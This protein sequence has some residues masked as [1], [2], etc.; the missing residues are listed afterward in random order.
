MGLEVFKTG[1]AAEVIPCVLVFQCS[2]CILLF[3]IH[4]AHRIV[5]QGGFVLE[6]LSLL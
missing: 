5:I 4:A 6:I 3:D 2:R 1:S